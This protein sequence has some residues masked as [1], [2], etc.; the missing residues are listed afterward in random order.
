MRHHW[1]QLNLNNS[2]I[3]AYPNPAKNELNLQL[4]QSGMIEIYSVEGKLI[5]A[6]RASTN[7]LLIDLSGYTTGIYIL[8]YMDNNDNVHQ[9]KF[10]KE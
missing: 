8:R 10:I 6:L 7:N 4:N 1:A 9:L 5:Q 3:H 2:S